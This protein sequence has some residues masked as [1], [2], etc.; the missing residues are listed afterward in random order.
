M[1]SCIGIAPW[2]ISV[3]L[4]LYTTWLKVWSAPVFLRLTLTSKNLFYNWALNASFTRRWMF[5]SSLPS[6]FCFILIVFSLCSCKYSRFTSH[7]VEPCCKQ[8]VFLQ[9]YTAVEVKAI[10][11][12]ASSVTKAPPKP[13]GTKLS[14]HIE[15]TWHPVQNTL[16][17]Q[18]KK[19][20]Y[21]KQDIILKMHMPCFP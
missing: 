7:T 4:L 13:R 3:R 12:C 8:Y 1:Q 18:K 5:S 15:L 2:A 14:V 19:G 11:F 9:Q 16:L 10:H 21:P 6:Q 17:N 20:L